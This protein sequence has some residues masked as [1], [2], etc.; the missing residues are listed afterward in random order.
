MGVKRGG[1]GD[2]GN[3]VSAPKEARRELKKLGVSSGVRVIKQGCEPV[4]KGELH[5]KPT[6]FHTGFKG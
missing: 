1:T 4:T 5:L 2:G 6:E 3:G